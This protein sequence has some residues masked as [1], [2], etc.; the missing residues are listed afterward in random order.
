MQQPKGFYEGTFESWRDF[1][2]HLPSICETVC[3]FVV[4]E[5]PTNIADTETLSEASQ[6]QSMPTQATITAGLQ[7][8]L[9]TLYI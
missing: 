9:P 3:S 2:V 5:D 4:S 7:V 8:C 6:H 1:S